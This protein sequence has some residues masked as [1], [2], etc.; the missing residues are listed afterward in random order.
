MYVGNIHQWTADEPF[1]PAITVPW[2]RMLA[3][4]DYDSL[5][6]GRHDL[7]EGT[8]MNVDVSETAPAATRNMEAHHD[9]I[10]IQFLLSGH[11]EIGYQPLC[12]AGDVVAHEEGS[13]NWFYQPDV[14]KDT[15]IPMVPQ[16]TFAIFTPADGHRCLCAPTGTGET[17][18]KVII[19]V[20]LR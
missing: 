14:T 3:A 2:V 12:Q 15:V 8:F 10:D 19:K 4:L 6:P 5:T 20:K 11:E 13:D 16:G 17:I 9:Y 1:I 18:C 7:G